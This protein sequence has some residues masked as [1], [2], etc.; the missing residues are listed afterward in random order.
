MTTNPK[1]LEEVHMDKQLEFEDLLY[2]FLDARDDYLNAMV[3][4]GEFA[5]QYEKMQRAKT[6]LYDWALSDENK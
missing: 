5:P 1:A 4:T 3:T 6:R 2:A